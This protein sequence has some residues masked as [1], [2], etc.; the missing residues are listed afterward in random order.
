MKCQ[1]CGHNIGIEEAIP[2]SVIRKLLSDLI[3]KADNTEDKLK[4]LDLLAKL[5]GYTGAGMKRDPKKIG[6]FIVQESTLK[7]NKAPAVEDE[8]EQSPT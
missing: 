8:P 7:L 5:E 1:E 3:D 4:T 2:K 6:V